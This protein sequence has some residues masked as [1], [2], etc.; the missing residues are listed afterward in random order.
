MTEILNNVKY[1]F[2]EEN[3]YT[4][5][6][7]I[8]NRVEYTA[9]CN[10]GFTKF[11]NNRCRAYWLSQ[12][13]LSHLTPDWKFHVSVVHADV[14]Q[15][16]DIIIKILIENN[17]R[18]GVKTLYL[19][20]NVLVNRGRE[21]TVYILKYVREYL[22]SSIAVEYDLSYSDE[23]SEEY[24]LNIYKLIEQELENNNIRSNG[25]A[26]GD[27]KLGKYISLR[28]EAYVFDKEKEVHEYP[29]DSAGWNAAGH[30][31]PFNIKKFSNSKKT[32][33]SKSK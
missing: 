24:W 16:W 8:Q 30:R 2:F 26:Q 1:R 32:A 33:A 28:N 31:V 19:K 12:N 4:I 13:E 25:T 11:Y 21:I 10:N 14:P 5:T 3:R 29:P 9:I 27:L 6:E 20:E 7:F 15:A 22:N 23:H 18:T 17:F